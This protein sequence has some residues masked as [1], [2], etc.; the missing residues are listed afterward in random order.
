SPEAQ[1]KLLRFIETGEFRRVGGA[2]R[3]LK[4]DVRILAATNR[5]LEA[6]I[7]KGR[8]REDLWFRLSAVTLEV[9][10]L[11]ARRAEVRA[12]A[13]HFLAL[14]GETEP[15]PEAVLAA[16]A[17]RAWYGNIRELRN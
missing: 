6:A 15:L 16:L 2:E 4:V 14:R 13:E 10:P 5:D 8:F 9:P 11:R 7:Q 3:L 12:F 1:V 17:Q